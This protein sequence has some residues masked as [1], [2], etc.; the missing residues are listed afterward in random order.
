MQSAFDSSIRLNDLDSLFGIP[1]EKDMYI[2][3]NLFILCGKKYINGRQINE[4]IVSSAH[5]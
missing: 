3:I 2:I 1:F 5:F 4:G